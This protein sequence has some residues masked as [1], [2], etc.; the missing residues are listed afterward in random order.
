[1]TFDQIKKFLI[2]L[3]TNKTLFDEV[4][5]V[6]TANEIALIASHYGFKFTGQELKAISKSKIQGVNIKI[7]D[8]SPSYNFGEGG[9]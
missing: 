7:Q 5:S 9:N 1:M 3:K 8:T 4:S 2:E 6:A